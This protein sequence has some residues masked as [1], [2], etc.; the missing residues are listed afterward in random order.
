VNAKND[1]PSAPHGGMHTPDEHAPERPVGNVIDPLA[2]AS[3]PPGVWQKVG[4]WFAVIGLLV[5]LVPFALNQLY[6]GRLQQ[7]TGIFVV[8]K[9]VTESDTETIR[10]FGEYSSNTGSEPLTPPPHFLDVTSRQ[11]ANGQNVLVTLYANDRITRAGEQQTYYYVFYLYGGTFFGLGLLIVLLA[12]LKRGS[13]TR[14]HTGEKLLYGLARLNP[15][16]RSASKYTTKDVRNYYA[17][18]FTLIVLGAT[19]YYALRTYQIDHA[20]KQAGV[21][22]VSDCFSKTPD[23]VT[24]PRVY[25]DGTFV[26]DNSET[27]LDTP[28]YFLEPADRKEYAGGTE[29]PVYLETT[30]HLA[31][32]ERSDSRTKN[33]PLFVI[34]FAVLAC[35]FWGVYAL[36]RRADAR[37]ARNAR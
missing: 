35:M 15:R 17:I 36:R 8:E 22:L 13:P 1:T 6:Y 5:M 28:L 18:P 27:A 12:R 31:E 16:Y 4:L 33:I 7:Q 30:G 29:V 21:F 37:A 34:I 14:L 32:R 3:H 25:C 20:P 26:P 10:C 11:P 19:G 23:T 24:W 9:C 2:T